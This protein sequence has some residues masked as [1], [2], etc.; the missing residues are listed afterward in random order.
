[1]NQHSH[2]MHL[3]IA[4]LAGRRRIHVCIARPDHQVDPVFAYL[5]MRSGRLTLA[6]IA[7]YFVCCCQGLPIDALWIDAFSGIVSCQGKSFDWWLS[8]ICRFRA[9]SHVEP[10]FA[11][12]RNRARLQ[13]SW[14][15]PSC[16]AF[17]NLRLSFSRVTGLCPPHLFP[18]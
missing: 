10:R 7:N 5:R 11:S 14:R 4:K 3:T 1:M 13:A 15:R 2:A 12:I 17:G 18:M 16:V 9:S 6:F 8:S